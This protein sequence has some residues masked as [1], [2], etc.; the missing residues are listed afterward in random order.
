MQENFP[1]YSERESA[2]DI[3]LEGEETCGE[4]LM[5][6]RVFLHLCEEMAVHNSGSFC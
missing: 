3:S 1:H 5:T 2:F 6:E 4:I